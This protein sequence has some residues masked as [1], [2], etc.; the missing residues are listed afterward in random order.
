MAIP[1]APGARTIR[2]CSLDGRNKGMT[3]P[4]VRGTESFRSLGKEDRGQM[5]ES[6]LVLAQPA[7]KKVLAGRA[8]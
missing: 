5:V 6:R 3:K 2:M 1:R 7:L 8:Q 4:P